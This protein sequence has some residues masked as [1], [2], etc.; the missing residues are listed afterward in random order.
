MSAWWWLVPLSYFI[1]Q[2]R[3]YGW[4]GAPQS[5]SE[6]IADGV[7]LILAILVGIG[8]IGAQSHQTTPNKEAS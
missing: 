6:L 5:D 7:T 2:N 1:E 4:H 3:Y 8:R